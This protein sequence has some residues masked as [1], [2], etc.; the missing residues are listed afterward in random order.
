M[1]SFLLAIWEVLEIVIV[2][3][4]SVFIIRTFLVQPFLVNGASMEPNFGNGN[5]LL[6]DEI[7]YHLRE[8]QRGEVV[9]FR[10]PNNPSTFYIKRIVGLPGEKIEVKNG[11]VRIFNSARPEGTVLS[12]EYLP[13]DLKTAGNM[14]LELDIGNYFVL[15]DNRNY[16]F[17]SR[18]WGSL[19]KKY[20]IGLVRARLLPVTAAAV[21]NYSY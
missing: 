18:S 2:A 1:K 8:P 21:F 20:F 19:N 7:T 11:L 5:Y 9:V 6:I 12:E 15:G 14:S 16:S 13:A 10:Y 3:V 4:A 17:D